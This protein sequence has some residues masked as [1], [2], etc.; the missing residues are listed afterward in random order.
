MLKRLVL[1]AM[2]LVQFGL[3]SATVAMADNPEPPCF[4]CKP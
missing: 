1:L 2:I 4:P 3:F